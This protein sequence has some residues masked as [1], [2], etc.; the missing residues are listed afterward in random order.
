MKNGYIEIGSGRLPLVLQV[1]DVAKALRLG[2]GKVYELVRCGRLRSIK[3]GKKIL[4]PKAAIFEFLG[5]NEDATSD[6]GGG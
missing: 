3:V 1:A 2:T 6:S 5:M 4:I